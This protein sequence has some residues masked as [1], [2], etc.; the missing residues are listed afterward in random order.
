MNYDPEY[1]THSYMKPKHDDVKFFDHGTTRGSKLIDEANEDKLV[2]NSVRLTVPAI[3]MLIMA[4]IA[5]EYNHIFLMWCLITFAAGFILIWG[6]LYAGPVLWNN[7]LKHVKLK[8]FKD[9]FKWVVNWFFGLV[10]I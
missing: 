4:S 3:C 1:L 10:E 7:I 2:W 5:S 9:A 8:H 6:I